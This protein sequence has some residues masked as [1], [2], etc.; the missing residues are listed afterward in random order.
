MKRIAFLA[1]VSA[2]AAGQLNALP[3]GQPVALVNLIRSEPITAGQLQQQVQRAEAAFGQSLSPAQRREV[4]D[5]MI[6][7]RLVLQ[8]AER[9]RVTVTDN[10]LNQHM[11]Q[12][13]AQMVPMLGRQ[14][15][16]AEFA[17]AVR[18][19]TGLEMAAFREETRRELIQQNYLLS[20][21]RDVLDRAA[22]PT[23]AEV[24]AMFEL[25]RSQFVRPET[26]R[27]SM[28]MVPYGA[29]AAARTQARQTIDG[30]AAE[31]GNSG[32]RFAEVAARS[33]APGSGFQGGD[34]GFLPRSP[35]AAR[36]FGQDFINRAFALRPGEISSVIPGP[37]NTGYQLIMVT[38]SH[39][40]RILEPEDIFHLGTPITVRAYIAN[41]MMQERQMAALAEAVQSL[42]TELRADGRT[43]QVFESNLN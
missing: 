23:P 22:P 13:R 5:M 35:E 39:S 19:R 41:V 36:H 40:M 12:L 1:L 9:D 38:E 37:P 17:A 10:E 26:V 42:H 21:R 6:N 28:I 15:T 11:N 25:H 14:P 32:A 4:L 24:A 29:N 33:Q 2:I 18:E 3:G 27:I 8:A 7:E 16:D 31:I 43:F 34:F 30:F 20:R